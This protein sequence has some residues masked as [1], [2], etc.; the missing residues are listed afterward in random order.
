MSEHRFDREGDPGPARPI[1]ATGWRMGFDE[2]PG[3]ME[4]LRAEPGDI[5]GLFRAWDAARRPLA[6]RVADRR[7]SDPLPTGRDERL[8]R[9]VAGG[10]VRGDSR[11][12]RGPEPGG[13]A[14][15]DAQSAADGSAGLALSGRAPPDRLCPGPRA[16]CPGRAWSAR[17][18]HPAGVPSPLPRPPSSSRPDARTTRRVVIGQTFRLSPGRCLGR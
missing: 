15:A 10:R 13:R 7:E 17:H 12:A 16:R 3:E 1:P 11:A 6:A 2:P 5:L 8:D 14:G 4:A 18:A 9:L